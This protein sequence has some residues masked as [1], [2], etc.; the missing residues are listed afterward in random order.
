MSRKEWF[1]LTAP[2][3]FA[4]GRFGFTCINK[5]QGTGKA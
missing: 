3:P 2:V 1:E 4:G 5:S